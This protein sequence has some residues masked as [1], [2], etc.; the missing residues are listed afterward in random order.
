M[1]MLKSRRSVAYDSILRAENL[2]GDSFYWSESKNHCSVL[3]HI[4]FTKRIIK[5]SAKIKIIL[6]L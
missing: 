4:S 2:L 5:N 6:F 3:L 1:V